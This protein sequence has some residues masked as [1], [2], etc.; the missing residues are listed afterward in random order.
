MYTMERHM[1]GNQQL[2]HEESEGLRS[3]A[4]QGWASRPGLDKHSHFVQIDKK[5]A[6]FIGPEAI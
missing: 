1:A 3:S 2:Q 4:W 5:R 6:S